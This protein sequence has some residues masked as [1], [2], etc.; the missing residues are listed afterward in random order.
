MQ[1]RA[2]RL[3]AT[4]TKGTKMEATLAQEVH[5]FEASLSSVE[6]EFEAPMPEFELQMLS[7]CQA[8]LNDF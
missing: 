8:M 4:I 2:V 3:S 6:A 7:G 1:S 5:H